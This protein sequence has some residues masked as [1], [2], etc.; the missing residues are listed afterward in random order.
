MQGQAP[1]AGC[2]GHCPCLM[3]ANLMKCTWQKPDD[4]IT[5]IPATVTSVV[6]CCLLYMSEAWLLTY[7]LSC[8]CDV[9]LLICSLVIDKDQ[10]SREVH[11]GRCSH[12][13]ASLTASFEQN[14]I[15]IQYL[16]PKKTETLA[17][18]QLW[19]FPFLSL[20]FRKK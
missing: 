8:Q 3:P 16:V 6:V 7:L 1:I 10:I 4:M 14:N 17:H 5:S 12:V 20:T 19:P 2:G 13:V 9:P 11:H 18:S 15:I